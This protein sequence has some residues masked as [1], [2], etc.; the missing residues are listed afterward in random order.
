M[1]YSIV[2]NDQILLTLFTEAFEPRTIIVIVEM[3]K[4]AV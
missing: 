4:V 3:R 2:K 1:K